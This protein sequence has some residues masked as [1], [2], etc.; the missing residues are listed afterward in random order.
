MDQSNALFYEENGIFLCI[1]SNQKFLANLLSQKIKLLM[2]PKS[3]YWKTMMMMMRDQSRRK[4]PLL[5]RLERKDLSPHLSK[6]KF[7]VN[8]LAKSG[9][10]QMG[11]LKA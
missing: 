2:W 1:V 4:M 11:I 5:F 10:S 9:N 6:T 3:I 8:Q 7:R